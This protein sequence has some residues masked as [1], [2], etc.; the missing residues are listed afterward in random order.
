MAPQD[1]FI[2]EDEDVWYVYPDAPMHMAIC[3]NLKKPLSHVVTALFASKS[4]TCPTGTFDLAR[5]ATR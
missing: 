3:R 5:V 1:S 2:E 4:S